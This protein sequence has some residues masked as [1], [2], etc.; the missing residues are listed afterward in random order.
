MLLA[1]LA[2]PAMA[3]ALVACDIVSID[4]VLPPASRAEVPLDA[5]VVAFPTYGGCVEAV[6]IGMRLSDAEGEILAETFHDLGEDL[7]VL[8]ALEPEAPLP[9]D[10]QLLLEIWPDQGAANTVFFN[11]QTGAGWLQGV[12]EGDPLIGERELIATEDD[13][14]WWVSVDL[15]ARGIADPD[16]LSVLILNDAQGVAR[17]A[18][19]SGRDVRFITGWWVD[20]APDE[21][22]VELVQVDGGG[23][24]TGR[25]ALTCGAPEL[26]H[27]Q[28]DEPSGRCDVGGG[29]GLMAALVAASAV[30]RRR[31]RP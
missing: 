21:V 7:P 2:A 1:L 19:P 9:E 15:I 6:R 26:R 31:R 30:I 16:D 29:A 14:G 17:A 25:S 23:Q 10:S 24:E 27:I 8:L 20:D 28:P 18:A 22:C 3:D 11:F 12:P 5:R 13:L 4:A